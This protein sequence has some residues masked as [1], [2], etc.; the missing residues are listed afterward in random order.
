MTKPCRSERAQ[1][2]VFSSRVTASGLTGP[3]RLVTRSRDVKLEQ[4]TNS[5]ELETEH[6]DVQLQPAYPVSPIDA[7]SGFGRIDLVLPEKS[8]FDLQATAERGNGRDADALGAVDRPRDHDPDH[9][10]QRDRAPAS[11]VRR[12]APPADGPTALEDSGIARR[13][14]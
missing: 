14:A 4:F 9:Q 11:V 12:V 6:G 2:S 10:K 3:V 5:L 8:A 13:V 7:R 1:Y